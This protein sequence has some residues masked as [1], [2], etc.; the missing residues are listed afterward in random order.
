[1]SS[2]KMNVVF[3]LLIIVAIFAVVIIDANRYSDTEP[4]LDDLKK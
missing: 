2:R 4:S 3:V 1:M